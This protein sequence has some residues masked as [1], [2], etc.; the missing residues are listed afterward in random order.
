M[1]YNIRKIKD[2]EYALLNDFLYEAIFIIEGVQA[3]PKSV[4]NLPELQVYVLD[5]GKKED[6]ICFVAEDDEKVIGAVWVRVMNDYGHIEDGIPS[7]AISLYKEYRGYG[8]GT[9][10]MKK[11]L[12]ELQQRGYEKTSLAVQKANYAVKMYKNVG[13]EI[14][15]ENEEEYIMVCH[16]KN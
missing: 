12:Y 10:L 4:I 15:D 13:F 5:F 14:V 8:I 7:F 1:N 2:D 6:D 9:A 16:L 11:M 3:P